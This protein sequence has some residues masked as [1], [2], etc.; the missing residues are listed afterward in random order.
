MMDDGTRLAIA[1]TMTDAPRGERAATAERLAAHYGVS[2]ATVYR[3]ANLG[4]APRPRR[5]DRPEY[6]GWVRVAIAWSHRA[7]KP[8]PMDLAI[9]AAIKAG[10]LPPE[11]ADMPL[12]T[13]R[14]L[15]AQLDLTPRPKRTHRLHAE[16]PMQ[17]VQLDASTSEYLVAAGADEG[18]AT[19][20]TLHRKPG[21][22]SGYKNKPL[23]KD[24]LRVLV[25]GLWDMCTGATRS[26]YCVARGETSPR[27]ARLPLLGARAC[28]GSARGSARRARGSMGRPGAA[29]E[30]CARARLAR[31]P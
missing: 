8:V 13:V 27:R 31:T 29:P 24:R 28:R 9:A 21:P 30:V 20:L 7:P 19:R 18:D 4:G 22:A 14:R 15:R 5:P 12:A 23:G 17:A 11:A 3:I 26:R 10:A 1:E 25:Y 16:F 2:R 6:R